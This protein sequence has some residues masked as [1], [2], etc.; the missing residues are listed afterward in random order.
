MLVHCDLQVV[1]EN[2]QP[3]ADSLAQYQGLDTSRNRF[4]DLLISNLVTGCTA[5]FNEALARKALPISGAAIMHDWWLALVASAFG[6]VIYLD[7]P[8]I[9]YRQHGSNTIG[10]KE[11][12]A[13]RVA[14]VGF[15]RKLFTTTANAHLTEVAQQAA[16]FRQQ[17]KSEL[18]AGQLRA[19]R[20]AAAMDSRVGILQRLF[21]RLVRRL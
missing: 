21:F 13:Q 14:T 9:R 12:S 7:T 6:K 1:D 2:L 17:F 11:H 20:Y 19:L 3:I 15:F 8:L 5:L 10:A 18:N 16:A 4:S